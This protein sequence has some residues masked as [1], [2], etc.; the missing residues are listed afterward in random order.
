MNRLVKQ[1]YVH[2]DKEENS[3][4][5]LKWNELV[6]TSAFKLR[7]TLAGRTAHWLPNLPLYFALDVGFTN[8]FLK[9]Y[10][11]GNSDQ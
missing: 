1:K 7:V 2:F 11:F 9:P 4:R 6:L 10:N 3:T 5:P 8:F